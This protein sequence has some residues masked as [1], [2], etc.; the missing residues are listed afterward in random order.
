MEGN[1][2]PA[3]PRCGRTTVYVV[4][5]AIPRWLCVNSECIKIVT[6]RR[7]YCSRCRLAGETTTVILGETTGVLV[8]YC[9]NV[10]CPA[11][12]QLI[13]YELLRVP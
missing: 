9:K 6:H 13:Y 11:K 1:Q 3:C 2:L 7:H 5:N 10:A 4:A 12:E 8:S